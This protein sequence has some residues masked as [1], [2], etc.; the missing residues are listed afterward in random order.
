MSSNRSTS[1]ALYL[2]LRNQ[3]P[4]VTYTDKNNLSNNIDD[5]ILFDFPFVVNGEKF[6]TVTISLGDPGTLKLIRSE[7]T[8]NDRD[9][10]VK[11]VWF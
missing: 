2:K 10:S 3:F 9:N 7:D 5:A 8:L 6:A 11:K 4:E 1:N